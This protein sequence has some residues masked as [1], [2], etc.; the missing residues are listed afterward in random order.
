M[1]DKRRFSR[2]ASS[3]EVDLHLEG[4]AELA[5]RLH[6]LSVRGL[7]LRVDGEV[8]VPTRC[9]VVMHL[10]GREHGITLEVF[11]VVARCSEGYIGVQFD[12]IS[13]EAFDQL[14]GLVL[15][16]ADQ[17][18]VIDEEIDHHFGALPPSD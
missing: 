17:P 2:I 11:G 3:L 8:A 1:N 4:G 9:R 18:E 16:S 15:S 14:R 5:G 10:A 12:Q 13:Y 6:D 7:S